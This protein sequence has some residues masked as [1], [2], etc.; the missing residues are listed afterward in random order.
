MKQVVI[1]TNVIVSSVLSSKGS[2][3]QIMRLVSNRV[4]RLFYSSAILNEY[5][6]VLAYPKLKIR[7]QIQTDTI[8]KLERL[9]TQIEPIASSIPLPDE[10]DRIFYDTAKAIGGILI[11][12]NMKHYPAKPFIMTPAE[13]IESLAKGRA[14]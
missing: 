8:E 1:D 4:I 11:T 2:P 14:I 3:F 6:R 7:V 10:T 13:F 9:G 5:K 12:G